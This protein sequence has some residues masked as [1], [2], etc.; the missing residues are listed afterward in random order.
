MGAKQWTAL[1]AIAFSFGAGWFLHGSHERASQAAPE[2]PIPTPTIVNPATAEVVSD[3]PMLRVLFD[4]EHRSA[5]IEHKP[6]PEYGAT[7]AD[8]CLLV[9]M[10]DS[11][12]AGDGLDRF[13]N[14]AVHALWGLCGWP[15]WKGDGTWSWHDEIHKAESIAL[16]LAPAGEKP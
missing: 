14:E 9:E 12:H 1:F 7:L 5:R 2:I 3:V 13:H 10:V 6:V 16:S 15:I 4:D 8:A 11:G